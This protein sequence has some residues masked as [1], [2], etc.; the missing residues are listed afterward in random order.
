MSVPFSGLVKNHWKETNAQAI[1]QGNTVCVYVCVCVSVSVY[2]NCVYMWQCTYVMYVCVCVCMYVCIYIY[3]CVC[4]YVYT[5]MY[6]YIPYLSVLKPD[7]Y[8]HRGS[9]IHRILQ[10]NEWNKCLCLFKCRLPKLLNLINVKMVPCT[11][12]NYLLL[13][14]SLDVCILLSDVATIDHLQHI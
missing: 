11:K 2:C 14:I 12:E 8:T 5:G 3:V 4:V 1:I 13:D 7:A 10:H 6:I 9:I